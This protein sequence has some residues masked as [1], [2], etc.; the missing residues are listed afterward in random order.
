[1]GLIISSDTIYE[2]GA[3]KK[4]S[5]PKKAETPKVEQKEPEKVEKEVKKPLE[6]QNKG[7]ETHDG[8][9]N[10][11]QNAQNGAETGSDGSENPQTD[12]SKGEG[13]KDAQNENKKPISP[14]HIIDGSQIPHTE[15][16]KTA[17]K[18]KK[19]TTKKSNAKKK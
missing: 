14:K 8:D 6:E 2:N 3:Y 1:M 10:N 5:A 17:P 16:K 9:N 11:P 13:E 18:G 12:N 4:I 19:A 15:K 7:S